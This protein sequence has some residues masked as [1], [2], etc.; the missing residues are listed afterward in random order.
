MTGWWLWIKNRLVRCVIV[1]STIDRREGH[2]IQSSIS[3]YKTGV[4][5]GGAAN[6]CQNYQKGEDYG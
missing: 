2:S 4:T 5:N 3:I 1:L 6:F